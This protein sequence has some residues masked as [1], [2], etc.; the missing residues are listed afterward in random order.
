VTR[1][2][3]PQINLKIAPKSLEIGFPERFRARA[4]R[5]LDADFRAGFEDVR[6][7]ATRVGR[8]LFGPLIDVGP[9]VLPGS[10]N[11]RFVPGSGARLQLSS[12]SFSRFK[13]D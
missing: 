1:Q 8:L 10:Q 6:L 12:V 2:P 5:G 3:I 4:V 9:F 7:S 13:N 11:T